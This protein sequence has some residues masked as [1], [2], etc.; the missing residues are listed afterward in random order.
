[1]SEPINLAETTAD[2][3]PFP[4]GGIVRRLARLP[5]EALGRLFWRVAGD[6]S[7]AFCLHRVHVGER[8]PG[9]LQ[10][11]LSI[12]AR[13]LDRLL[14]VMTR[15]RPAGHQGLLSFTFDDGYR[16]AFAYVVT[17]APRYPQVEWLYFVCP[18]KTAERRGFRWDAYELYRRPTSWQAL[19]NILASDL[20]LDLEESRADLHGL[21]DHPDFALANI[22]E[23][24][25]LALLPN[26]QLGNHSNKHFPAVGLDEGTLRREMRSSVARFREIFGPTGHFAFP[27][28]TP[29]LHYREA[30]ARIIAEETGT[31]LWSTEPSP[32]A[33]KE[34]RGGAVLPRMPLFGTWTLC[35]TLAACVTTAMR[36]RKRQ[37]TKRLSLTTRP[38]ALASTSEP[39][40]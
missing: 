11:W 8:R 36:L 33:L 12:E 1:M 31:T 35:E 22:E 15:S 19:K 13:R 21:A 20:D 29:H 27:F 26:V 23:C 10:P 16:D 3:N 2:T 30:H 5:P 17:R 38:A 34:R 40:A 25:A 39:V 18:E 9:E 37:L 24:Q 14:E 28:G 32:Y 6:A 7:L 4:P